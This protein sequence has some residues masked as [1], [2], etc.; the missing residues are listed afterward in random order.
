MVEEAGKPMKGASEII[1][2]VNKKFTD[3]TDMFTQINQN[4][5][6]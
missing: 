3:F 5:K 4:L 1:K 6:I 2:E